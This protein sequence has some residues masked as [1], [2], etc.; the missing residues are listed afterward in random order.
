MVPTE[1]SP[2]AYPVL[3]H[4]ARI[5]PVSSLVASTPIL[6]SG[7]DHINT[8]P[9]DGLLHFSHL[10]PARIKGCHRWPQSLEAQSCP[11][12]TPPTLDD[13]LVWA[14][15]YLEKDD[16]NRLRCVATNYRRGPGY[17]PLWF[18]RPWSPNRRR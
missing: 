17:G 10:P 3:D 18:Y 7:H 1:L 4:Q 9:N 6:L 11:D 13:I 15:Q 12:K 14:V 16:E 2:H 5:V 8:E